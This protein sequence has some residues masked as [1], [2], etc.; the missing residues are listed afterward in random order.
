MLARFR[1]IRLLAVIVVCLY[2]ASYLLA[3]FVLFP[4]SYIKSLCNST[5][6]QFA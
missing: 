1:A 6:C 3:F 2:V 5:K 4:T